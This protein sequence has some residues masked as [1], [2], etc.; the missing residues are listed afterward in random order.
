MAAENDSRI[1]IRLSEAARAA[2]E[3]IRKLGGFSTDQEA[4]RR[5]IG[6]ER[7]IQEKIKDGWTI[8]LKKDN[9]YRELVWPR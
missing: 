4:I 3:E 8:L 6:D 2:V 1:S 5:A 9:E 7:F